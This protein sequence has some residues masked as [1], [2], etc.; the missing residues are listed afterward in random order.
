MIQSDEG[1][2][3]RNRAE[4]RVLAA[5][6]VG[7]ATSPFRPCRDS[8]AAIVVSATSKARR[9]AGRHREDARIF[10]ESGRS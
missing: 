10:P 1:N 5:T 8:D 7:W 6:F 9:L 2:D 3:P 4:L